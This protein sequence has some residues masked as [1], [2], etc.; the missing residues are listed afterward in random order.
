MVVLKKFN[1]EAYIYVNS[2]RA[3]IVSNLQKAKTYPNRGA[4]IVALDKNLKVRK[5]IEDIG[6]DI[7]D[8]IP[9]EVALKLI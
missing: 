2:D 3:E 1:D 4:A 6:G 8:F 7:D 9:V 5:C